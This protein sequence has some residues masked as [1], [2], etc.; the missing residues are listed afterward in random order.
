[1]RRIAAE[2]AGTFTLLL[3]GCGS[4]VAVNAAGGTLPGILIPV[5]WGGVG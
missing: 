2:F 4:I 1:M 3:V 5:A